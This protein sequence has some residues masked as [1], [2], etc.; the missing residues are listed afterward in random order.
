MEFE[1]NR[2]Q[3]SAGLICYYNSSKFHYLYVSR[4]EHLGK[5]LRV[6]S[7]LPDQ[8]SVGR[9]QRTH[10]DR[11]RRPVRL[12]VEIDFERLYFAYA[13]GDWRL[14]TPAWPSRREHLVG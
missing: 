10:S 14:V 3:Q 9:L 1:P 11:T 8:L 4:D 7:C 12:R 6:M 13:V 2:F 5:H